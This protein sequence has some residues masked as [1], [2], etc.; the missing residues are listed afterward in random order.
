ML[1]VVQTAGSKT[2]VLFTIV[3]GM[4]TSLHAS[5]STDAVN[6]GRHLLRETAQSV[7]VLPA[8]PLARA[9]A[10]YGCD[11]KRQRRHMLTF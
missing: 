3:P 10:S 8:P 2:G 1:N 4:R 6:A 5:M 11:G 7:R 9:F